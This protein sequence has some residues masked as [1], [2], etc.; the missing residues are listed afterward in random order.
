MT[1]DTEKQQETASP[2]EEEA[3]QPANDT[4][5]PTPESELAELKERHL[6]TLAELE[7][8]H[9][10]HARELE[11]MRRYAMSGFARDLLEVADNLRRA[12][13][14]VPREALEQ[15]DLLRNLVTGV[16]MTERQLLSVF[17]KYDIR[18][19]EPEPGE[20]FSHELHHAMYEVE[21]AD[22]RPGAVAEVMQVG[23]R[24]GD[25]LLRPARVG[26]AKLPVP[27]PEQPAAGG[28]AETSE[29]TRGRRID[30]KA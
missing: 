6:R 4:E 30:T 9:R 3:R 25:R 17:E 1:K 24:M 26:I 15:D 28:P 7:N 10:R 5:Q 20:P 13:E 27:A 2:A 11:E 19:I 8:L 29:E 14:S 22:H 23:Y 12:L 16:E 21:T 18:K